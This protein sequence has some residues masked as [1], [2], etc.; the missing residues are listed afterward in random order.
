MAQN[1]W[2][3]KAKQKMQETP[4]ASPMFE[5]NLFEKLNEDSLYSPTK[6]NFDYLKV[7]PFNTYG[8]NQAHVDEL[9]SGIASVGLLDF[10]IVEMISVSEYHILS[11]Q[12]RFLA[13][14]KLRDELSQEEF[15]KIFPGGLVPCRVI[16]FSKLH[17]KDM[18]T[19]EDLSIDTKRNYVI[20]EGNQYHEKTVSDYMLQVELYA[21][22]YQE[23]KEKNLA[24][25][26]RLREFTA[27]KMGGLKSR[28]VQ[29][30]INAKNHM[31]PLLWGFLKKNDL[32]E[33]ANQLQELSLLAEERQ[34]VLYELLSAGNKVDLAAYIKNSVPELKDTSTSPT[35]NK[36]GLSANW[37]EYQHKFAE[38]SLDQML[39][40]LDENM[41]L[42]PKDKEA[43]DLMIAKYEK[44]FAKAERLVKKYQK[45]RGK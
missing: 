10:P 44:I 8:V 11:G 29:K 4:Q 30:V 15:E 7:S 43:L 3:E 35:E 45:K 42:D 17:L 24:G 23:L 16:D 41:P 33:S 38:K 5:N 21:E 1:R 26:V 39:S 14:T 18:T 34:T 27:E 20:A 19:G 40:S 2:L 32:L 22:I 37:G 12:K 36:S 28:S 6:V 9:A 31:N 13:I 25:G